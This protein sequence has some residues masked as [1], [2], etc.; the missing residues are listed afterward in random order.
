ML[1][2]A[3][4]FIIFQYITV[5][6]TAPIYFIQIHFQIWS[7]LFLLLSVPVAFNPLSFLAP[8]YFVQIVCVCCIL[9]LQATCPQGFWPFFSS[10][11]SSWLILFSFAFPFL[12]IYFFCS[13]IVCVCCILNLQATCT[14]PPGFFFFQFIFLPFCR[15][16]FFFFLTPVFFVQIVSNFQTTCPQG[17]PLIYID[18][19]SFSILPLFI[20]FGLSYSL[21]QFHSLPCVFL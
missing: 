9:S 5:H 7:K 14:C 8:I 20:K 11:S 19:Y 12:F 6:V 3:P 10:I 16:A 2:Y 13:N 18:L 15:L 21:L 1:Q 17:V 4:A